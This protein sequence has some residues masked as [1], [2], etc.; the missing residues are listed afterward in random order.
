[1]RPEQPTKVERPPWR[2]EDAISSRRRQRRGRR[3]GAISSTY[4]RWAVVSWAV[5]IRASIVMPTIHILSY[6]TAKR[7]LLRPLCDTTKTKDDHTY[8]IVH[9]A[10]TLRV[11]RFVRRNSFSRMHSSNLHFFPARVPYDTR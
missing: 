7:I 10:S 4:W 3:G 9:N 1:M 5:K 8:D 2:E 6:R 11:G